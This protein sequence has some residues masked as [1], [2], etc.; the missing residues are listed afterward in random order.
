MLEKSISAFH[1]LTRKVMKHMDVSRI[2]KRT[3]TK[4][5]AEKGIKNPKQG[6][7]GSIYPGA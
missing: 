3:A 1:I 7:K 6:F 5:G 2:I 4:F